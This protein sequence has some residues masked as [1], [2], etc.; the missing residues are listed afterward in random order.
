[1]DRPRSKLHTM[2]LMCTITVILLLIGGLA[3]CS[4]AKDQQEIAGRYTVH[5]TRILHKITLPQQRPSAVIV[6]QYLPPQT[7]ILQT[8][9]HFSSYDETT[10]IV[11]WLLSETESGRLTISITL[12]KPVDR[13]RIRAEVL[14]KDQTGI[15]NAFTIAPSPLKRKML[16][17]C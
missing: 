10:G 17:G 13:H 8:T 16:E 2:F 3:C 6:V 1:M 7:K 15:S 14:F 5:G 12:E 9:P 4:Y 11:K